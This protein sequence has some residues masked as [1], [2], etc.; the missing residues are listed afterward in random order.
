[1]RKSLVA[2]GIAS[3][4]VGASPALP[5]Q[6]PAEPARGLSGAYDPANPFARIIRGE[7]PVSKV[8]EDRLVL[9]FMPLTMT[10]PGHVLVIPKRLGPRNLLDLTPEEL[11]ACM[12]AAQK[13]AR[14]QMTALGATGFR[15]VQNN[16]ADG[17]QDVFHP[18]FHVIPYVG[19]DRTPRPEGER[20]TRAELDAMAA[21]LRAA[22]PKD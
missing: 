12:V 5:R 19:S 14:A 22:W 15:I 16:G 17:G 13:A 8:Y 6:Q 3:L 7:A 18:H 20:N 11:A 1:M 2:A 9:V 4:I 21:R 10:K